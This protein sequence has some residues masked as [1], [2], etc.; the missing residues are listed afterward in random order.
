MSLANTSIAIVGAGSVGSSI[1]HSLLLR[2][3][4]GTLYL[5]D[6]DEARCHGQVL[7]LADASYLSHVKVKQGTTAEAGQADI[8]II[9]AGAKQN[10]GE[11]RLDLVD[12]NYKILK[13]ILGGMQPIRK[14]A[15]LL[16]VANPVDVLTH[17]AQD[18]SGLPRNQVLGSGTLLDS[19][20]LRS[21]I[22]NRLG[23]ADSSVNAHVLG[24]HGDSQFIHWSATSVA[25]APLQ[26]LLSLTQDERN[27]I[28]HTTRSK[29]Q[30]IIAV[31]GFTAYGISA[32][33]TSICEAIIYDQRQIFPVS[34][35][36]EDMQCCLSLPAIV[37]RAGV[38][39]QVKVPLNDEEK[40]QLSDSAAELRQSIKHCTDGDS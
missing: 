10:P 28:A 13:S 5:V 34:H 18:L 27:S 14:D 2:R 39:E 20:R 25:G 36:Q 4:V 31:K 17:F 29:A 9:T 21:Q 15:V 26:T 35:W 1:A 24:E 12:R 30:D 37:G 32:A 16:L 23:V 8:I 33:A 6:I 19:V 7:D 22:A 38:L 3:V 11:T 40:Q